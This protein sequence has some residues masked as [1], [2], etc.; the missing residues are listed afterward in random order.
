MRC[1]ARRRRRGES[2]HAA[3]SQRRIA[4]P[5]AWRGWLAGRVAGSAFRPPAHLLARP[6]ACLPHPWPA[7]AQV[8]IPAHCLTSNNRHV[9]ARQLWGSDVY[10]EDSDLVA[11]VGADGARAL[12]REW[13]GN[14]LKVP[15]ARSWVARVLRARGLSQARIAR[16]MRTTENTVRLML[17]GPPD[18]RQLGLPL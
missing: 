7:P 1:V 3:S 5:L 10:T 12:A 13:G 11:L 9:R 8:R 2:W 4:R 14:A 16:H 18:T 15:L 6:P 17:Q